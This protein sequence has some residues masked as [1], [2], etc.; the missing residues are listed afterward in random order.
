MTLDQIRVLQT[1]VKSGSFRAASQELHRAQSA[2][3]YAIRSLE[4][5]VGFQIFNRDDYRPK[6]TL[7]GKAFLKKADDLIF[8]FHELEETTEFL[9]R[10]H[11]PEVRIAVSALWPLP[12]LIDV[13][14]DF[15]GLFP[16]TKVKI[17]QD[18]LSNDEQLL[19]DHADIALG[20]VFNDQGLLT[21]QEL[22]DVR[23]IPVCAA[24]HPLA[25]LKNPTEEQ[26]SEHPQI[27]MASTLPSKRS[28]GIINP[29]N[30]ISVQDY[31][32]KKSFLLAGLGWGMMPEH[33]IQ[34]E[35]KKKTLFPLKQKAFSTKAL[36]ARH[37]QKELGPCGKFLWNYFSHRQKGRLK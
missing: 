28:A 10:G 18:V 1:I 21:T 2:V 11:E 6:L 22:F 31:L 20:V 35:I 14:K 30:V 13:L 5:E 29:H 7:Q 3:S 17:I 25:K 4:D 12:T 16:H 9:K 8:Q 33:V 32:T 24:K 37:S 19:E 27:I 36:I 34:E 26:L 15:V 23:M